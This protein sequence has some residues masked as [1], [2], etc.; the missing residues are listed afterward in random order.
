MQI[1]R[2][3]EELS[4]LQG[5]VA[6]AIGVFDGVHRGHQEVICAAQE[7]AALHNGTAVVL[8]FEPHPLKVLRPDQAPRLLCSLNHKLVMLG[9]LG[10]THSVVHP[11]DAAFAS[12]RAEEFIDRLAKS[13]QPLGFISVGYTWRFG[14][15]G[16]GDIH[17]LMDAGE[18]LGFGVYGVPAVHVDG[19]PV[20]STA[21]RDALSVGDLTRARTLLGR[22]ASVLGLVVMGRQLGR[23][24]GFPTANVE[25]GAEQLPPPGVYA[26][27]ALIQGVQRIGVANLGLRPTIN[28]ADPTLKLEVHLFNFEGDLYG[29]DVE[30]SFVHRIRD[31]RK[32]ENLDEL[33]A[34]IARDSNQ[35]RELLAKS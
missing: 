19:F 17:L 9:R 4:Q 26:V 8:T 14:Q 11:F 32:F 10:I 13:C 1:L 31:E 27:R 29:Q 16:R 28:E 3:I 21:I 2:S 24:I 34:Q 33:K 35:A 15:G 18:S 7:Y 20:S 6:L 12:T 23:T 30:V 25:T 22:D 5:P